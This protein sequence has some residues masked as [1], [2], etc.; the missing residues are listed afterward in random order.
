MGLD[1]EV[2]KG[3]NPRLIH[4]SISGFGHDDVLPASPYSALPAYAIICEAYSGILH[5]VGES[6]DRPPHWLGFALA[7]ITAGMMTVVGILAALRGREFSGEGRRV[8]I[9][10][11]D[12]SMFMNDQAIALY[13]TMSHVMERGPYTLQAPWGLFPTRDGYIAISVM[14]DKQWEGLCRAIGRP[15]LAKHPDCA[16]GPLRGQHMDTLIRPSL[17]GWLRERDRA[18]AIR[19]LQAQDVPSAPVNTPAD[20]FT[21][22]HVE[23][24]QMLV[25]F[26]HPV[27]GD[28]K[29]VGN[30]VKLSGVT[31][32][33]ASAP[34]ELGQHTRELLQELLGMSEAEVDRLKEAGVV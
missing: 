21:C 2:L 28:V 15:D 29:T 34:P 26:R 10:M 17:E 24:R 12:A 3:I 23:A 22:R 4:A 16:T 30:P 5:L 11:Y 31:A 27:V 9:S 13:A 19:L 25:P 7:D 32:M 14:G 8:D 33:P 6:P 20:L 1:Y 18:E